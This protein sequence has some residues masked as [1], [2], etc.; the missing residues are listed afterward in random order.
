M[1]WLFVSV[2]L[3]VASAPLAGCGGA[4]DNLRSDPEAIERRG[5]VELSRAI[6]AEKRGD[7][8]AARRHYLAALDLRSEHF[9]TH[10]RASK[11]FRGLGEAEKSREIV[12]GYVERK[13]GDLRGYQLLADIQFANGE[14]D[15]AIE[16]LG[17]I[18]AIDDENAVAFHKRG[19]AYI[20]LGKRE[21][22]LQDYR[23][24]ASLEPKNG[25][26]LTS[27]GLALTLRSE[28]QSLD[29]AEQVLRQAL[30]LDERNADA[31]R[32][33]GTVLR[34]KFKPKA[35]LEF[36]VRAVELDP[37][38]AEAYFELGVTQ[39]A[40]GQNDEAEE[41]LKES[42]EL[43]PNDSITWYAFGEVLRITKQCPRAI[44]AYEKALELDNAHPKVRA[45]LGACYYTTGRYDKAELI[46]S[47][48]IQK[49][50]DDAY[51]YFNLGQVYV[52]AK[53][54][55][56]AIK[57]LRKFIELAPSGDGDIPAAKQQIGKLQRQ[58]RRRY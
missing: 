18:I 8:R 42:L 4:V 22:A 45:K 34:K 21:R 56:A 26:Y 2:A 51:P 31:N 23:K 39:N 57:A 36:H 32:L 13:P 47:A 1:R 54:P 7:N 44:N 28:K 11:F 5:K 3:A 10:E 41:S 30:E 9:E 20:A 50:P 49:N 25:K 15:K 24:A 19:D 14:N 27:L 46:L 6:K 40:L 53:R 17:E 33:L 29:E 48:A 52:K 38:S 55:H 35:A 16:T 58:I 43:D 12:E 37:D